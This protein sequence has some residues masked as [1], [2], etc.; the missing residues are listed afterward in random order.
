MAQQHDIPARVGGDAAQ[1][2]DHVVL[3]GRRVEVED[4]AGV[5]EEPGGIGGMRRGDR[6][7]TLT[8]AVLLK[9]MPFGLTRKTLPTA[10]I[11]PAML[12]G[13]GS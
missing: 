6:L 5:V 7:P 12:E 10:L 8:R 11:A 2:G 1:V 4:A 9:T 13:P 3:A